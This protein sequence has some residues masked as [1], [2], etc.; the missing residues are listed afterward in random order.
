MTI[1]R[2]RNHR[3]DKL[4]QLRIST[5]ATTGRQTCHPWVST[6]ACDV[7]YANEARCTEIVRWA[8]RR[9]RSGTRRRLRQGFGRVSD[10]DVA[11]GTLCAAK[12]PYTR[13]IVVTRFTV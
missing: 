3:E 5:S 6:V 8:Q 9:W 4:L 13:V 12:T 10:V 11:L 1:G 7:E 2:N